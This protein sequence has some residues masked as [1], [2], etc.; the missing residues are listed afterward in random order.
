MSTGAFT[1][2][3]LPARWDGRDVEWRAWIPSEG[4]GNWFVMCPPQPRPACERCGSTRPPL[5]THGIVH[6]PATPGTVNLRPRLLQLAAFRCPEC[7]LDTVWDRD[8]DEWWTLDESDYGDQGSTDPRLPV[9]V[10]PSI[11][12]RDLWF[13]DDQWARTLMRGSL[14]PDGR[15][16]VTDR[17][18]ALY[19]DELDGCTD[20]PA[21]KLMTREQT[22]I[23]THMLVFPW[24]DEPPTREFDTRYLDVL[25]FAGYVIRPIGYRR[26][27][28]RLVGYRDSH[29]IVSP[30]GRTVGVLAPVAST[31]GPAAEGATRRPR[32]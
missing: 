29:A 19:V 20:M 3:Q 12:C 25:E 22:R 32:A 2:M 18:V 26:T 15:V 27:G 21:P 16:I 17:A 11:S 8:T 1:P 23:L 6:P 7:H 14:R 28:H 10:A 30:E 9:D 31:G 4:P 24:L 5:L 13:R